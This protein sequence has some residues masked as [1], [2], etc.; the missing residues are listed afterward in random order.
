MQLFGW[1]GVSIKKNPSRN[2]ASSLVYGMLIDL[3]NNP[4]T[5]YCYHWLEQVLPVV[6]QQL[7]LII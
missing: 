3:D 5:G 6:L 2:R 1:A 4:P 7:Y